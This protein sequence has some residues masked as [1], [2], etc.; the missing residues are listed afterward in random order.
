MQSN[1]Y[2]NQFLMSDYFEKQTIKHY[3]PDWGENDFLAGTF[4]SGSFNW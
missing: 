2:F 1:L 4:H 3:C